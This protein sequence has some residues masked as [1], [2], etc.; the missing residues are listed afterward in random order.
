[1]AAPARKEESPISKTVNALIDEAF[2]A[3]GYAPPFTI[4][5]IANDGSVFATRGTY[6]EDGVQQLE[7]LCQYRVS[8]N[9]YPIKFFLQCSGKE[10]I[11]AVLEEGGSPPKWIN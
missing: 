7:M 10:M 2:E 1:M 6:D 3:R 9:M 11:T 4:V 8:E 5:A